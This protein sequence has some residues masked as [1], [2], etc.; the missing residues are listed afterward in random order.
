M[1]YFQKRVPFVSKYRILW[2]NVSY[3][4][5]IYDKETKIKEEKNKKKRLVLFTHFLFGNE[6][7]PIRLQQSINVYGSN[8]MVGPKTQRA[9]RSQ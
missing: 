1:I 2:L 9:G 6:W 4:N 5:Y 7:Y 8:Q 3:A